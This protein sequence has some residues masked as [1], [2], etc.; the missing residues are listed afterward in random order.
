MPTLDAEL[1]DAA[2][3]LVKVQTPWPTIQWL[4]ECG[5]F[6]RSVDDRNTAWNRK[7]VE[8]WMAARR[9]D[10]EAPSLRNVWPK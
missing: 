6:P 7:G 3:M 8:D 10:G 1:I 4:M 2:Q 9:S 5:A